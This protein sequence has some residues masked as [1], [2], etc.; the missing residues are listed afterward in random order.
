M[1]ATTISHRQTLANASDREAEI[2]GIPVL[3]TCKR[4]AERKLKQEKRVSESALCMIHY[5]VVP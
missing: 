4:D 5:P 1:N 3:Q 2:F